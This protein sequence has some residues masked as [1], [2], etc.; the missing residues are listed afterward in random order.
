M[1]LDEALEDPFFRIANDFMLKGEYKHFISRTAQPVQSVSTFYSGDKVEFKILYNG[2]GGGLM[3]CLISVNRFNNALVLQSFVPIGIT[4]VIENCS[5]YSLSVEC[6]QC[7]PGYHLDGGVCFPNVEGCATY[8]R[9]ICLGCSGY[10]VLA[11]N[12]CLT[13]C[14]WMGDLAKLLYWGD[15][16]LVGSNW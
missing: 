10:A 15:V 11:E 2:S 6:L 13:G 4:R 8:Y 3:M 1:P 16:R 12:R 14:R 9:N 7:V 5:Q